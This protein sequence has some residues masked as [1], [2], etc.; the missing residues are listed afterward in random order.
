VANT[1]QP[2]RLIRATQDF[3]IPLD[4]PVITTVFC[5]VFIGPQNLPDTWRDEAREK[6]VSKSSGE[7]KTGT[8]AGPGLV[9]AGCPDKS[10]VVRFRVS[11]F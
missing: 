11:G 1:C 8:I 4:A 6:E 9:L 7:E 10:R 2:R 5:D 3:P